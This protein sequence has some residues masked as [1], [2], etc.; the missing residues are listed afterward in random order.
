[1]VIDAPAH[2]GTCFGFGD[3][4]KDIY[5]WSEVYVASEGV[6]VGLGLEP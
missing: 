3:G 5:C 6:S 2:R 1:M 4:V